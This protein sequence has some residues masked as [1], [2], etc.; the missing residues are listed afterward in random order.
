MR[1][2]TA[3]ILFWT[4]AALLG[5]SVSSIFL[6]YLGESI[7]GVFFFAAFIFAS[8]SFYGYTTKRDLTSLRS[9]LI[10]GLIGL[11]AAS[12]V[13]LFLG[14]LGVNFVISVIAALVFTGLTAFDTQRLKDVFNLYT[15]GNKK[16]VKKVAIIG[17]LT[18]YL[19]FINIFIHLLQ[20]IGKRKGK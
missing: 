15:V 16:M 20:L 1:I 11:L 4:Y 18:L 17:A 6:V 9:F 12:V 7:A 8:M 13:N 14:S 3:Q 10:M 5:L 2:I 19:D